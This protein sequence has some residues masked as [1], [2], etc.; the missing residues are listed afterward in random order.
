[1]NI[2]WFRQDLRVRDNP[3]LVEAVLAGD[4]LPIY[5]LDDINA[6]EVK[7]GAASRVWLHHA[8]V[9]LDHALNGNLSLYKGD[10]KAV[11]NQLCQDNNIDAVYWNRCYEPWRIY[12]DKEIKKTLKES[13]VVVKS[14][15]ASLLW[16][17]WQVLKKDDT[18]YKVFTPFYR[19]KCLSSAP[20]LSLIHI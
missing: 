7:M 3:A 12:R 16:E 11:I 1:M 13:G 19:R 18:P 10:A 8:L 6:K 9:S 5:I 4:I 15:N 17:P 20:P 2:I 14:F